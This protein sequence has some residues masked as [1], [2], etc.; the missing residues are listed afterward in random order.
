MQCW[1]SHLVKGWAV[2]SSLKL[3]TLFRSCWKFDVVAVVVVVEDREVDLNRDQ[4]EDMGMIE[5][6][7]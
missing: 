7:R 4:K 1:L 5:S 6:G 3:L 2:W